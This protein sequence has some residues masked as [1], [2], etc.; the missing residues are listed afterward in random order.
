MIRRGLARLFEVIRQFR[1]ADVPGTLEG[2]DRTWEQDAPDPIYGLGGNRVVQ[3]GIGDDFIFVGKVNV[4]EQ[5]GGLIE[6][7]PG[8][9][10]LNGGSGGTDTAV[11][12]NRWLRFRQ[13][14]PGEAHPG[15]QGWS[16]ICP[17]RSATPARRAAIPTSIS[18]TSRARGSTATISLA[19]TA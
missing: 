16:S 5:A 13:L 7:H 12:W 3:G 15:E 4:A 1:T 8:G 6:Q 14:A 18:I 17:I 10:F 19:M 9:D 11:Y 2:D